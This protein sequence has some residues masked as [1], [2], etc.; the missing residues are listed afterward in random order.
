M[1]AV[2]SLS[3][4]YKQSPEKLTYSQIQDYLDYIIIERKLAWN[5]CNVHFSGIKR[6][7]KHVLNRI[8]R[9]STHEE[10][11]KKATLA[12]DLILLASLKQGL[13]NVSN[14]P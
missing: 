2:K 3:A 8:P 1:I 9:I 13:A 7:Y 12:E 14:S 6:F 10:D 11:P 5:T 4:H